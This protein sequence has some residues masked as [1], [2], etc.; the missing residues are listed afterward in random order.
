MIAK[1]Q[2]AKAIANTADAYEKNGVEAALC[3]VGAEPWP[4][5]HPGTTLLGESW[6]FPSLC[7]CSSATSSSF[8]S[9][10]AFLYFCL[11]CLTLFFFF[12]SWPQP[13]AVEPVKAHPGETALT[14]QAEPPQDAQDAEAAAQGSS[15]V[16]EVEI[17]SVGRIPV[18]SDA[19]GYNEEVQ[20]PARPWLWPVT[21]L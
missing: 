10:S 19:D 11:G 13:Q 7:S 16:S 9:S 4:R 8:Q 15:R 3:E 14:V 1:E 6:L 17:P 20:V 5:T 21:N 18:R 12:S 2:T